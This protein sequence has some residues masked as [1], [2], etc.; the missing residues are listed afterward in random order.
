[1][2]APG[3]AQFALTRRTPGANLA[4][5]LGA[6]GTP[7]RRAPEPAVRDPEAARAAFDSFTAGFARA[8][9]PNPGDLPE[10]PGDTKESNP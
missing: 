5:G 2:S 10:H 6:P 3:D 4:P 9:R 1:V 7:T 8:V